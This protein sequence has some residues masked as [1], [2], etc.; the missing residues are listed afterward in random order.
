MSIIG[1][2]LGILIGII[3][4]FV[5]TLFFKAATAESKVKLSTITKISTQLLALPTFWF[6]GPWATTK[7]LQPVN[8]AEVLPGYL[9]SL[10]ITFLLLVLWPIS[11][12]VIKVG[13]EVGEKEGR[14]K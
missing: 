11:Q 9:V 13:N 3:T 14:S 10:T 5:F 1:Y 7:F 4:G 2:P 12:Y 8:I 6:G